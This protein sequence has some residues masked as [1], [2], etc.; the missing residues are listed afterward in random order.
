MKIGNANHG[1]TLSVRNALDRD[2]LAQVARVGA[3]R[4]FAIN[5]GVGW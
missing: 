1:V 4:E 2:L 5:Y 3:G